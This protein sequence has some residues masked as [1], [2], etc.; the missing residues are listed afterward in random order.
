M[1][2]RTEAGVV[3][4]EVPYGQDGTDKHWGCPIREHWGL[5]AH[6][7]LSLA[8][9]EKLAFTITA[10]ASYEEAAALARRWG[11]ICWSVRFRDFNQFVNATLICSGRCVLQHTNHM[12]QIADQL[13]D[14]GNLLAIERIQ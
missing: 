12:S 8:L 5:T 10:T 13:M 14:L 3:E 4:L 11:V 7:Q 6:Q 9:E 2:L 1:Q